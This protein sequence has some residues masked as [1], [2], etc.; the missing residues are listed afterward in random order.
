MTAMS[1]EELIA[2]RLQKDLEDAKIKE[3]ITA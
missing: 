1:A 3:E 2:Y